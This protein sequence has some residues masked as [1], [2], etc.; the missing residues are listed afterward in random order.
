LPV[1]VFWEWERLRSPGAATGGSG[2][3]ILWLYRVRGWNAGRTQLA[4]DGAI[5]LLSMHTIAAIQWMW[6]VLGLVATC[7]ILYT[8]HRPGL[9]TGA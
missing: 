4:I 6:S 1:A 7:G 3:A 9:Y 2:V 8:W 5:L